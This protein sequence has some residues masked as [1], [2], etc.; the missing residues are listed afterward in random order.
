[1]FFYLCK[2]SVKVVYIIILF[3][4]LAV[5][6]LGERIQVSQV[7]ANVLKFGAKGQIIKTHEGEERSIRL[8]L[9]NYTD[10]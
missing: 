6:F 8:V 2:I 1:M 5:Q 7:A 4:I 9:Y 10:L 3:V